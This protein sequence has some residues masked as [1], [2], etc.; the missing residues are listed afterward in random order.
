MEENI[1]EVLSIGEANLTKNDQVHMKDFN[2]Y[3]IEAKYIKNQDISR[4][5]VMVK[6]NLTYERLYKFENDINAMMVF[7]IKIAKG[8]SVHVVCVY[9]QWNLLSNLKTP[10]SHKLPEQIIRLNNIMS[11]IKEIRETN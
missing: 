10:T 5:V 11:V 2:N 3:N 1:R 4:L 8:Q 7:K 6:K 9:C